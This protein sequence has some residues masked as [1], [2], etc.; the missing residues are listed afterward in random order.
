MAKMILIGNCLNC[1]FINY[2]ANG[3]PYCDKTYKSIRDILSINKD[4]PLPD[5]SQQTES[6]G[7]DNACS[8]CH[9]TGVMPGIHDVEEYYKD[10]QQ[11]D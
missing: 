1:I 9:G 5:A 11:E 4:C 2:Q 8:L 7:R 10:E 6:R 3:N